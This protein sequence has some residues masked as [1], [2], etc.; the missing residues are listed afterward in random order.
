VLLPG[1]R[2]PARR[3]E[4]LDPIEDGRWAAF[5]ARAPRAS[6]HHHRAW[7]DLLH[8]AFGCPVVAC[9]L[10]DAA[11][12][13][14]AGVPLA[15]V[16]DGRRGQRLACLPLAAR[17]GALPEPDE[18]PVLAGEL[19]AALDEL[20][21]SLRV[22]VE[23]RGP[24]AAHP[25]VHLTASYRAHHLTLG[26]GLEPPA[27]TSDRLAVERR[28]DARALAELYRLHAAACRRRGEPAPP[29]RFVLGFA[30]LFDRGLGFVLLARHRARAVAGAVLTTFNRT[31]AYQYG[32]PAPDESP[33]AVGDVLLSAAIRW[34]CEAGMRTLELG[35]VALDDE[36]RRALML[37]L[38]AQETLLDYREM[39]DDE[40][41]R[42]PDRLG[43]TA[44]LIRRTPLVVSRAVGE[45]VYPGVA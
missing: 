17:C 3:V 2:A 24:S 38:G 35:R 1:G 15:L 37:A 42:R 31:L 20:R 6:V 28:T 34:G 8:T 43:W 45:T 16:S 33:D 7:L 14:Q 30:H 32:G 23:L 18:D 9:C 44:P 5:V 13:I 39:C 29:R 4:L 41:R 26:P 21:C 25:A 19:V 10:V 22:P 12:T 40:P 11:G 27:D 36:R